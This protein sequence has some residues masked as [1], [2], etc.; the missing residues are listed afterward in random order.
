MSFLFCIT[1]VQTALVNISL[2]LCFLIL[3]FSFL[4]DI[5]DSC[6]FHPERSMLGILLCDMLTGVLLRGLTER[7]S[8]GFKKRIISVTHFGTMTNF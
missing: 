1:A 2:C 6:P 8:S 7:A 5:R 4:K 3:L